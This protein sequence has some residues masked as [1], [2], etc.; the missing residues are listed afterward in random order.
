MN[1]LSETSKIALR[2]SL[3]VSLRTC[4]PSS[5]NDF[6]II[7]MS[8]VVHFTAV[9]LDSKGSYF[10]AAIALKHVPPKK[11][12]LASNCRVELFALFYSNRLSDS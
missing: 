12:S 10:I 3:F 6:I 9:K 4:L 7:D 2:V 5:L 8:S 1:L 11:S